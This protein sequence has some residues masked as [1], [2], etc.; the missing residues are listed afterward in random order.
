MMRVQDPPMTLEW[1]VPSDSKFNTDVYRGYTK[2]GEQVEYV[3]WPAIYLHEDGPVV[4]KGVAQ[5]INR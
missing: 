3:V 2:N 1:T 5:G 4:M